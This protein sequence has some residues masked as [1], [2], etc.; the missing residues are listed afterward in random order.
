VL[1]PSG[2]LILEVGE[3]AAALELRLP[4]IPFTWVDLPDG[5]SGV[6]AVSAQ[7]LRDWRASGIL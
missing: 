3:P 4:R 7:E 6:A 2:L 5:G 1:A